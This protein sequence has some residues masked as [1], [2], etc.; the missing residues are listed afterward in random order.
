MTMHQKKLLRDH[1]DILF[2]EEATRLYGQF[3]EEKVFAATS[4]HD[5][6]EHYSRYGSES[7]YRKTPK[8]WKTENKSCNYSRI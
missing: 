8:N 1:Y 5:L 4:L 6:D 3:D 2:G 7:L